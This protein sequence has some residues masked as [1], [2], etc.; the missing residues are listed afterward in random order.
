[1][2][3][4]LVLTGCTSEASNIGVAKDKTGNV[5]DTGFTVS[6]VGS[7]DSADT[8]VVLS[9]DLTNKAVSLINMDTG[10]QYT[11][12]YDGTTYVKDKYD[13]PMT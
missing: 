1:M 7:Y 6:A 11:L 10:K 4:T 13:G 3:M 9:T 8:A 12:Y 5:V 2:I